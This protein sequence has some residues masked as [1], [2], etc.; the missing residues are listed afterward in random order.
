M[1][2]FEYKR[3]EDTILKDGINKLLEVHTSNGWKII[4]YNEH[5]IDQKYVRITLLLEKE[6]GKMKL[7]G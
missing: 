3:I 1:A 6:S 7:F 5:V 2:K 4:S